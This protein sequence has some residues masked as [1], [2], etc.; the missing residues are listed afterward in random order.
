MKTKG[1]VFCILGMAMVIFTASTA[2]G[3]DKE[4][5]IPDT[6]MPG[7]KH[8][9]SL[10]DPAPGIVPDMAL[11]GPVLD[12]VASA[13]EPGAMYTM[14]SIDDTTSGYYE[15]ELRT[16]FADFLRY[17][18]NPRIMA[19]LLRPS[20]VRA[21]YWTEIQQGDEHLDKL[22][23][24][25]DNLDKPIV[26]KGKRYVEIT[27]DETTGTYYI[28]NEHRTL[29][30]CRYNG[31]NV[32]LS[33]TRQIDKS[34]KGRRGAVIGDDGQWNYLYF[35]ETGLNKGG[36]S[37]VNPY[38][39]NSLAVAVFMETE[40]GSATMRCADFKWVRA[41]WAGINMVEEKHIRAGLQRFE[42]GLRGVLESPNPPDPATLEELTAKLDQ[43]S[44]P[45]L[46]AQTR[47]A[48][49]NLATRYGDERVLPGKTVSDIAKDP[50][51]V[52]ELREVHLRAWLGVEH[53]KCLLDKPNGVAGI[54]PLCALKA[55]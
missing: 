22:W 51:Y 19:V 47:Q 24:E 28:Y 16:K 26:I 49:N 4:K 44:V 35:K 25:L 12:F 1:R 9:L 37:W 30:L 53:L 31:R 46:K 54:S 20:S 48:I 13:K 18:Y 10:T 8:L 29:V 41:G 50:E 3:E 2:A 23:E 21:S 33:I 40:P 52:E 45:E 5:K 38:I 55:K 34:E 36:L 11:A 7:L 32:L 15:Y 42:M 43:L 39:Y 27:P 17:A 6:L 14:E